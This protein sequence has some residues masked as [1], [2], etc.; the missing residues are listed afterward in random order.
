M[1]WILYF[2][3]TYENKD[4]SGEKKNHPAKLA[5]IVPCVR[6]IRARDNSTII[7][8]LFYKLISQKSFSSYNLYFKFA[9]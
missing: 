3:S 8:T 7:N 2:P 6:L 5:L 9:W 4:L 1:L